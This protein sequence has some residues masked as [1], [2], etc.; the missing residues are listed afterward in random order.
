MKILYFKDTGEYK[1]GIYTD[2]GIIPVS[3]INKEQYAHTPL[4][5]ED[6]EHFEGL[7]ERKNEV[8]LLK[9]EDL[10]IGP[11]VKNPSKII[12]VGLNYQRHAM[13]S[14]MEPPKLPVLFNKFN[15]TLVEYQGNVSL[16]KEGEEFDYEVELG[17]VIGKTCKDVSV[18][19]A[20]DYVL[21]YCTANDL[22]C[23][24]LQFKT[25]QWLLG[26]SLDKFLP[27]GK[28]LVTKDE[29]EDCQKLKLSCYLNGELRQN[30]N[31]ADMIF[32]VAEIIS[33]ISRHMTLEPG[34]LILTGT[35]EGVIMGMDEKNWLKPGD[36]VRVEIEKLGS[37]TNKM[38]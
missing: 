23:R 22:S 24:D 7:E 5:L 18:E 26:K 25:P 16:G 32:S 33:F 37:T 8:H 12:C 34:D 30:S 2:E 21:G 15:N 4:T 6:I 31:T 28:Y 19:E 9:E 1:P 29:I 3:Q 38:V 35:P 13:E 11:C 10:E 27:L 36:V 20:L 17:V 14:N